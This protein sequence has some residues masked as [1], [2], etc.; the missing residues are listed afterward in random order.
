MERG[1]ENRR[2]IA[3]SKS[4]SVSS[5]FPM[6]HVL[7][8]QGEVEYDDDDD[9]DDEIIDLFNFTTEDTKREESL[10]KTTKE[11]VHTSSEVDGCTKVKQGK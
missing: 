4:P 11:T 10:Q 6:L 3:S 7:A 5:C 9:D 2:N 1:G 8:F